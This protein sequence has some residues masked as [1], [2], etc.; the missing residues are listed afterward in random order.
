M[1]QYLMVQCKLVFWNLVLIGF[2]PLVVSLKQS[3]FNFPW[4]EWQ[5][6][7]FHSN[8]KNWNDENG[9]IV[10]ADFKKLQNFVIISVTDV[11]ILQSVIILT[12]K[13]NV[14]FDIPLLIRFL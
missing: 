1:P 7:H 6:M 13:N 14:L 10:E 12:F 4:N 8:N 2:S 5:S 11:W 9:L 3:V